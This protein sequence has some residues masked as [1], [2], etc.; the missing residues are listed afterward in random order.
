MTGT[1]HSRLI[2]VN[3]DVVAPVEPRLVSVR[4]RQIGDFRGTPPVYLEVAEHYSRKLLN[5]PPLCDE[6]LALIQHM[7]TEEEASVV[8]HMKSM[9]PR[10]AKAL[11]RLEHRPVEEVTTILERL[12]DEKNVLLSFRA[13]KHELYSILPI[14]PGTFEMVL[15]RTSEDTMTPWHRR[16]AQLFEDLYGTG[17]AADNQG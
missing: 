13:K 1:H 14:A 5:G 16:F 11:A 6:L 15:M 4:R 10:S 9:K 12:D 8:R 2:Q 3:K 17:R 7:F